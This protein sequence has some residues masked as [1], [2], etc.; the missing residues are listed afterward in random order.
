MSSSPRALRFIGEGVVIV[1]SI[2]L[3]LAA[4]AWW[5]GRQ[6][7]A[8]EAALLE[9]LHAEISLNVEELDQWEA[10]R[11]Q[12]ARHSNALLA[13]V[14]PNA[15]PIHSVRFD[16]LLAGATSFRTYHPSTGSI[17]AVL[18]S[19]SLL[20]SAPLRNEIAGFEER[21]RDLQENFDWYSEEV[22]DLLAH[23]R[24]RVPIFSPDN[25]GWLE[26]EAGVDRHFILREVEFAN[27][28][29]LAAWRL[30][31]MGTEG[32]DFRAYM[33]RMLELLEAA[34]A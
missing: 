24:G 32:T 8:A 11:A 18:A 10:L 25:A 31:H 6:D 9:S 1:V 26:A 13:L 16:S 15:P 4:D 14:R 3:A 12:T 7:R 28:L 21:L 29:G 20:R 19:L 30:G 22:G 33:V 27:L 34:Q 2:L 17:S 23:V 5:D